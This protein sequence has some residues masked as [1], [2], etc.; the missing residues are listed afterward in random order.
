MRHK[1]RK[2]L[3]FIPF[4]RTP[5]HVGNN[6]VERFKRWLLNDGYSLIVVR[7]GDADS[8]TEHDWGLEISVFDR[9]GL[10]PDISDKVSKPLRTRKP[11]RL[12]RLLAYLLF[13][14][15]PTVLWSKSAARHPWVLDAAKGVDFILSSSPPESAHVGALLLSQRTGVP[16]VMDMR[17]GWLDE[18]LKPLL[19]SSA[20]RRWLEGRIEAQILSHAS[21]ILVTSDIWRELL[22][23]RYDF[24]AGKISILT[25]GY[26]ATNSQSHMGVSENLFIHAGRFTG[27]RQTQK[28]EIL[29]NCLL[30]GIQKG[31]PGSCVKL[32]GDLDANELESILTYQ[33]Q[34][35]DKGWSL[36][37]PG[38]ISRAEVLAK[39]NNARGLL[40]LSASKAAIPS[41][42]FEY[43]P[44]KR[45][46]LVV[47]ERNSAVWHLTQSLPQA[48]LVDPNDNQDHSQ[49]VAD[50]LNASRQPTPQA[51]V[52]SA[53]SEE[54]LSQVF[55]RAVATI[56]VE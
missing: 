8:L 39:I 5:G 48:F 1:N 9:L 31:M 2:A 18:P 34:F 54:S 28:P 13:N 25:N 45:P 49:V 23:S 44:T 14:P 46:I 19:H 40:L 22:M 11:N 21:V 32:Y 15:D 50:F 27:S 41:K 16:L 6:R 17:D 43:I 20:F 51:S 42:L 47:S 4:F 33:K 37:C 55:K 7:A 24:V 38:P 53:Y 3:L 26:P 29:L 30:S 12:R 56:Y 10:H 36:D 52:P 35:F